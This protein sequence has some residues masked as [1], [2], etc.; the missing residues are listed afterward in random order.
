MLAFFGVSRLGIPGYPQFS[1]YN[2]LQN[3][4]LWNNSMHGPSLTLQ[5][6]IFGIPFLLIAFLLARRF[7]FVVYCLAA[8]Y[9]IMAVE[10]SWMTFGI[11]TVNVVLMPFM[12][13]MLAADPLLR[14]AIES[15]RPGA[16]WAVLAGL[17][18]MRAFQPPWA[19]TG[20]VAN[21]AVAALLIAGLLHGRHGSLAAVLNRPVLQTLGRISLSF[22]LFNVPVLDLIWS[23]TN[24]WPFAKTHALE[25]GLGVGVLSMILTWPLAWISERW[26]ERPSAAAGQWVWSAFH[27]AKPHGETMAAA[28]E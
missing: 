13:G 15:V 4:V 8:V 23:F 17:L 26:I 19:I 16:W 6:E 27:A 12:V 20:L 28:A 22:Y 21:Y 25:V 24:A 5:Q 2:L 14:P 3:A 18:V 11:P 7:G 10:V 9:S 1:V